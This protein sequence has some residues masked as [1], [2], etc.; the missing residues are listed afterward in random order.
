MISVASC[1][2]RSA[3]RA[4]GWTAAAT[5]STARWSVIPRRLL[6]VMLGGFAGMLAVITHGFHWI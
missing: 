3:T 4:L 6:G 2:A 1:A 5:G